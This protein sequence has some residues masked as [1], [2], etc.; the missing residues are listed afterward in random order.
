[1]RT[2]RKRH[3]ARDLS[4]KW[5]QPPTQVDCRATDVMRARAED[6]EVE[7]TDGGREDRPESLLHPLRAATP[8]LNGV[9]TRET[10]EAQR[11]QC[12]FGNSVT[13]VGR[14]PDVARTS[15]LAI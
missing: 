5:W 14:D 9:T 11:Q 6:C 13:V 3:A 8:R 10:N 7:M 4:E 12:H 15:A 1:M 2:T